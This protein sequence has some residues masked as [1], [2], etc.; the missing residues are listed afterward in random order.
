V[1][2]SSSVETYTDAIALFVTILE[3]AGSI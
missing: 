2:P 3:I 1:I